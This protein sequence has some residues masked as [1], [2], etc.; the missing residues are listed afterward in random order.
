M[1]RNMM[2]TEM[3]RNGERLPASRIEIPKY[4]ERCDGAFTTEGLYYIVFR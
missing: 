4:M 2:Y 3:H 1:T